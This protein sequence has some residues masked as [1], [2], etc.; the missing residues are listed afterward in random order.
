MDLLDD[1]SLLMVFKLVN[2]NDRASLRAT[3]KRFK[4]LCDTM[5]INKLIVF[6]RVSVVIGKLLY[7]EEDYGYED[8]VCCFDLNKFFGNETLL[9]QMQRL[10][11]L[12]IYGNCLPAT[13]LDLKVNFDKLDYLQINQVIMKSRQ[14]LQSSQ[15]KHLILEKVFMNT[16]DVLNEHAIRLNTSG[17]AFAGDSF[18]VHAFGFDNVRSKQLKYLCLNHDRPIEFEFFDFLVGSKLFNALDELEVTIDDFNSLI[19]PSEYLKNIKVI[20]AVIGIVEF[21][22]LISTTDMEDFF[23]RIRND[24]K[25]Y[26]LGIEFKRETADEL[27]QFLVNFHDNIQVNCSKLE[28]KI[29]KPLY[30]AIKQFEEKHDLSRFYRLVTELF[31]AD[32]IEDVEFLKKFVNCETIRF[33]LDDV[34]DVPGA[35][36]QKE[37]AKYY[38]CF[39]NLKCVRVEIHGLR[40]VRLKDSFLNEIPRRLPRLT[41][42]ALDCK[43][44]DANFDFLF[45]FKYLASIRLNTAFPFDQSVYIELIRRMPC[46]F[47]LDVCYVSTSAVDREQLRSFKE[48]VLECLAERKLD[49]LDFKIDIHKKNHDQTSSFVRYHLKHKE[50]EYPLLP[51][52]QDK[53]YRWSNFIH[54]K[55]TNPYFSIHRVQ[56]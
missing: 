3:N 49:N 26:L 1:Y 53:L 22:E 27:Q 34:K 50:F 32:L 6:E 45:N 39:P 5:K 21:F 33:D 14:V 41:L 40:E 31:F 25:I 44:S 48:R 46:L 54:V 7:T 47:R 23:P 24:L 29:N 55:A 9:K 36:H 19:L 11:V 4:A 15:L 20:N 28:L 13:K 17:Q 30:E 8:T 2:L 10:R 35:Y 43:N 16:E 52:E 38:H 42:F 37:L 12:V 18:S 51:E 56:H